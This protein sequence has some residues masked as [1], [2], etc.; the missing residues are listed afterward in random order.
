MTPNH[1]RSSRLPVRVSV[2]GA[3]G[4][5]GVA[6]IEDLLAHGHHV[7][8][9][10]ADPWAAGLSL[11]HAGRVAPAATHPD[12]GEQLLAA[13]TA[14]RSDA[15][16]S[17]VAEET[18][19]L[20]LVADALRLGG[21]ATWLPTLAAATVANDKLR[22]AR[23]LQ[24]AGIPHPATYTDPG[25]ALR[26]NPYGPWVVK[27]SVGRGSRGVRTLHDPE[28][29][30][31]AWSDLARSLA[32]D[33]N[34][35]GIVPVALVQA[36]APGREFTADTLTDR[37]GVTLAV[38]AR[39]RTQTR[40]G[41]ST[42]GETFEHPQVTRQVAATLAAVG[43]TGPGCVQGFLTDDGRV[44]VVELNPRFSGGLPL[45]L[46]AGADL[47]EAYL[48]AMLGHDLE[49]DRLRARPGVRMSRYWSAVY[50]HPA[51]V[52]ARPSGVGRGLDCAR[53]SWG[54]TA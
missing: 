54:L 42:R 47:V 7:Q 8:A 29:L 12:F 35:F 25:T 13:V 41:I 2:T 3:G 16:V 33:S 36:Y 23:V 24:A 53:P 31:A 10:D 45:T 20:H 50:E 6:V 9:L 14:H 28:Q 52:A 37:A 30:G 38:A 26:D 44:S 4:P 1:P 48:Q 43:H 34:A 5:A 49:P 19:A 40:D 39:W 17:T 22:F 18:P 51:D 15:L 21:T 46:A 11:A 27:P 32:D